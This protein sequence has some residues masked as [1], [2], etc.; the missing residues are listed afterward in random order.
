MENKDITKYI[1]LTQS[2]VRAVN[3]FRKTFDD[4]PTFSEA[5]RILIEY[6]LKKKGYPPPR[7]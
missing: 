5:L 7:E 4:I 3:D 2:E 1:R 6:A